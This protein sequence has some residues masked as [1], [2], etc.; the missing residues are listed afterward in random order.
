ML[1]VVE[2]LPEGV[3]I[4]RHLCD[5]ARKRRRGKMR[6]AFFRVSVYGRPFFVPITS[7]AWDLLGLSDS[8]FA[9]GDDED[10]S[11]KAIRTVECRKPGVEDLLR[12]IIDAIS[13]QVRDNV[14]DGIER[15]VMDEVTSRLEQALR[16]PI[17]ASIEGAADERLKRALPEAHPPRPLPPMTGVKEDGDGQG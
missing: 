4:S 13:L 16:A 14:L 11:G 9:E 5:K 10:Q 17:R 2:R 6:H 8:D 3:E 12:Q 15:S 7:E 1:D